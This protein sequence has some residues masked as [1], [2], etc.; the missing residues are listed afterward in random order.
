[1]HFDLTLESSGVAYTG[2]TLRVLA[3]FR[4][5]TR[6]VLHKRLTATLNSGATVFVELVKR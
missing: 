3:T 1:M 2:K 5:V 4:R 6:K